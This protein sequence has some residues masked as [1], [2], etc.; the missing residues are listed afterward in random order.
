MHEDLQKIAGA[1]TTLRTLLHVFKVVIIAFLLILTVMIPLA[2]MSAPKI[3]VYVDE[4]RISWYADNSSFILAIPIIIENGGI[5]SINDLQTYFTVVLDN[6]TL[7][8]EW[9]SLGSVGAGERNEKTIS[10]SFPYAETLR[11]SAVLEKILIS[12]KKTLVSFSFS[13]L[14]MYNLIHFSLLIEREGSWEPPIRLYVD[15][16]NI[17]M[18][19]DENA[20]HCNISIPYTILFAD[21]LPGSMKFNITVVFSGI[22][23][24]VQCGGYADLSAHE[25]VHGMLNASFSREEVLHIIR[26]TTMNV[27]LN[28]AYAIGNETMELSYNFSR[29]VAMLENLSISANRGIDGVYINTN[30]VNALGNQSFMIRA[31]VY[32]SEGD[33]VDEVWQEVYAEMGK[34]VNA[35][36]RSEC[37]EAQSYD[38]EIVAGG[39]VVYTER[40][41]FG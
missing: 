41:R 24:K 17:K 2:I 7:L 29:S 6:I 33:I 35:T 38:F 21:W 22:S 5:Y 20:E 27:Y 18:E 8:S 13:L 30:F 12:G 37:T 25:D 10:F 34:G 32:N 16:E 14:Y 3:H 19:W 23:K 28:I 15:S 11:N 26:G 40:G 39:I 36:L 4:E 9:N 1:Y 31:R